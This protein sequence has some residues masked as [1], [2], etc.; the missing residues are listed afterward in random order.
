MQLNNYVQKKQD[1]P[2]PMIDNPKLKK[3]KDMD[4][5]MANVDNEFK[6]NREV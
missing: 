2:P 5:R 3:K 1:I 6:E 4:E